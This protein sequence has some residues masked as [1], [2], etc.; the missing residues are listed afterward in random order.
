METI[1][2]PIED[3]ALLKVPVYSHH[4]R[5]NNWLAVIWPDPASPGGLGRRFQRKGHG[6]YYYLVGRLKVGDTVEFAADYTS[7]GGNK[8]R[9]RW[10]GVVTAITDEELTVCQYETGRQAYKAAKEVQGAA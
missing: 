1:T 7:G 5:G 6:D 2:L 10:Y 4:K 3:G 8:S 9:T